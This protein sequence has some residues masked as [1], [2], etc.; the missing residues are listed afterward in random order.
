M[1]GKM[2]LIS[3]GKKPYYQ[4]IPRTLESSPYLEPPV[5]LIRQ[6]NSNGRKKQG[7]GNNN[8]CRLKPNMDFG[9]R[10]E[11]STGNTELRRLGTISTNTR[12]SRPYNPSDH[13]FKEEG[14]K[15]TKNKNNNNYSKKGRMILL[16][17]EVDELIEKLG[18]V[19]DSASMMS[20]KFGSVEI[21]PDDGS[22]GSD[23]LLE[24]FGDD[25]GG[26]NEVQTFHFLQERNVAEP[27]DE[28]LSTLPE[29]SSTRSG[30]T[31][32][33]SDCSSSHKGKQQVGNKPL[34]PSDVL[35][36]PRIEQGSGAVIRNDNTILVS[37]E[38]SKSTFTTNDKEHP[39]LKGESIEDN[40]INSYNDEIFEAGEEEEQDEED[41][42]VYLDRF[43]VDEESQIMTAHEDDP[44]SLEALSDYVNVEEEEIMFQ[45][46][47]RQKYRI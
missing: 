36:L 23:C 39:I 35:V 14:L 4:V 33:G 9:H 40:S 28:V 3:T 2:P 5:N 7:A 44:K 6:I 13:D 34:L 21:P 10:E 46:R 1:S 18:I 16:P 29:L 26:G 27:K 8:P 47:Q 12:E 20:K 42:E 15:F 19:D 22:V 32:K 38:T 31:S 17:F 41:E 45:Q 11:R 43:T 25:Y 30:K 37:T 24:T